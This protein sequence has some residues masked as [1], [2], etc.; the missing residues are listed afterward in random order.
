VLD[1]Q[2]LFHLF[3]VASNTWR[4]LVNLPFQA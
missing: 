2:T 3:F 4:V 1:R